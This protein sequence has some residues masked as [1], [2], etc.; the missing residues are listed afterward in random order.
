M[1]IM[2]LISSFHRGKWIDVKLQVLEVLAVFHTVVLTM[3]NLHTF[4]ILTYNETK[5]L[6]SLSDMLTPLLLFMCPQI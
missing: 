5:I 1:M 6:L 2:A 3:P 4:S